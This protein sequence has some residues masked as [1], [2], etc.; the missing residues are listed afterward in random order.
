MTLSQ[1]R[2]RMN[3]STVNSKIVLSL[4]SGGKTFYYFS[5]KEKVAAPATVLKALKDLQA[6]GFIERGMTE[7]RGRRPYRLT[8]RGLVQILS[9]NEVYDIIDDIAEEYVDYLPLIFGKWELFKAAG[10]RDFIIKRFKLNREAM[11]LATK[12]IGQ[13]REW[14]MSTRFGLTS[15]ELTLDLICPWMGLTLD[16]SKLKEHMHNIGE[17]EMM[18]TMRNFVLRDKDLRAFVDEELYERMQAHM[19][20]ITYLEDWR[21]NW[22]GFKKTV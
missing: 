21:A 7:A 19:R 3:R 4:A 18:E 10:L 16:L 1:K 9:V 12:A 11:D 5:K 20:A 14:D 8:W 6:Q 17:L 2:R 22:W 13:F 15:N